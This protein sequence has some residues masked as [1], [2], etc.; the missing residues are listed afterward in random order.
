MPDLK[1]HRD[2]GGMRAYHRASWRVLVR[3]AQGW[4][5]RVERMSYGEW[6]VVTTGRAPQ[7]RQAKAIAAAALGVVAGGSDAAGG[8]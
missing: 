2:D 6:L 8:D 4:R 5:W 7:L 1:W 3:R